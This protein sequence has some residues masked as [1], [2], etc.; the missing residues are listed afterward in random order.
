VAQNNLSEGNGQLGLS[1]Q[2][3]QFLL[4]EM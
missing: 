3:T 1:I 2:Q 4:L